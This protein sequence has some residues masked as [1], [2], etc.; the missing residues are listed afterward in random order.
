MRHELIHYLQGKG[1][2]VLNLLFK[3][4]W[5]IEGMAY[6]LSQ[7]PRHKLAEP[8]QSYRAEFLSW[9]ATI[10]KSKIWREAAKL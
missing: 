5:F 3:P 1:L 4:S 7:D 6:G 8:F 9:Y 2:G 10:D